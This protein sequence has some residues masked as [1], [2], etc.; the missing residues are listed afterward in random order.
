MKKASL[1]LL[2]QIF[3]AGAAFAQINWAEYS[4]SYADNAI[5]ESPTVGLILAL[6]K[7]NDVLWSVREKSQHFYKL[8][9]DPEFHRL[10]SKEIIART[11]FD[12][13]PAQFFLHG[14]GPENAHL[15][16]Y[17]VMEYPNNRVL[18]PWRSINQFTDSA[19]MK[20]SAMP[21]M[22]Y[23][24]GY[25][26]SFGKM[27]IMD[28]RKTESTQIT[29]T[30]LVAW[31]SITPVITNIYTSR[32]LD[33]FF[34][35]LQYP[36]TVVQQS[37]GQQL[38]VPKVPATNA[39]IIFVLKG[40]IFYKHQILYQLV[41]NGSVYRPWHS[42]DY[43]NSFVWVKDCPPGS[44][45]I[46]I[47]FS[48][49]P[50]KNITEYHFE[51]A[52]AWYQTNLF[53]IVAGIFIAALLG[54][55]LFLILFIRQR[56]KTKQELSNKAKLQLELKAIYA[57]LNPHFIFNA[58]SSI[59]GLINKQ[60]IKGA[61]DYLSDFARL[62]RESLNNSNKDEISLKEEIQTLD[63][64]LKLEQLRFGFSYEIGAAPEMNLYETGIPALLLQPLVENAVK[65]GVSSLQEKGY[66]RIKF[67]KDDD[68]MIVTILDNGTG[69]IDKRTSRGFGL[70]LTQERINLLNQLNPEQKISIA[71]GS[72]APS[73]TQ[74]TLTFR[75][76][77]L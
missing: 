32:N 14:V 62:L 28:V 12:T 69:F 67:E 7:G 9:K 37:P 22:A 46:K 52:P 8:D 51:I 39:N 71:I 26:T 4:Q 15:Y 43:D 11:T 10:R 54:S 13:I 64:Y 50:S 24:G 35:K 41:R 33:E 42:N 19:V 34:K 68:T 66:I 31:E 53:K 27:L 73:G 3:T 18:I 70:K 23:L 65:H 6:R 72:A 76:W 38:P 56:Q 75:H 58:L 20:S 17:R 74:I 40:S 59:Q 30:S 25:R 16:Q 60:D 21:K 48:G 77:F 63:T 57:Q 44:Y 1:F 5:G 45:V 55:I 36:W 49:Q 2:I 47:R 61:N 29:A